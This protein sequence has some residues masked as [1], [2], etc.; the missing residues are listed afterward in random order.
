MSATSSIRSPADLPYATS[1]V[2]GIG[3]TIKTRPEDFVVE[4][5]PAYPPCGSGEHLFLLIEK[6]GWTTLDAAARI[7]RACGVPRGAVGYA[8]MKDA[9]AVTRQWFSVHLPKGGDA[10]AL[11]GENL[12]VL[13]VSR[14]RNKLKLGHLKGNRFQVRLRDVVAGAGALASR[15]I[16]ILESRGMPNGFGVQ[17]FGTRGDTHR[18]GRALLAGDSERFVELA[19]SG[20]EGGERALELLRRGETRRALESLPPG[21]AAARLV[22]ALE[23]A[24]AT[25]AD[26]PRF[27]ERPLRRLYFAAVQ[28]ECFNEVLRRRFADYDSVRAG[29][30]AWLHRNGAC[31][32][33]V[34]LDV[35]RERARRLEISASG[36]LFGPRCSRPTLEPLAIE[37]QVLADL[38]LTSAAFSECAEMDGARRPLRVP[39]S[40]RVTGEDLA[41]RS[42]D[43]AI[44]LPPGAYATG[45][46]AELTKRSEPEV[47]AG[48][49]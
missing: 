44:E 11:D 19:W 31:F 37:E 30:L 32:S 39:V 12:R 16:A 17:R 43:V 10:P 35:E 47:D 27:V 28:A 49:E 8:G 14:H 18:L 26:A 2:P 29:D 9:R 13:A 34:D 1:D 46:L 25:I 22:A 5:I 20:V 41:D 45:F 7:A 15:V 42:L 40:A 23:R 33:V 4:E 24:G 36:P 48:E 6:R 3:G 38:G 21:S